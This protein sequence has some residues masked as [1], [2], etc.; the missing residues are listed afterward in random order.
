MKNSDVKFYVARPRGIFAVLV[1]TCATRFGP[2]QTLTAAGQAL[3]V[4]E[5]IF[6]T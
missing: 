3:V 1:L 5:R 4:G 6:D 2:G